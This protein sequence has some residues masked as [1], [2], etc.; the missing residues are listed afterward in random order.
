MALTSSVASPIFVHSIAVDLW[1]CATALSS[2]YPVSLVYPDSSKS[3]VIS[4]ISN[5]VVY[6]IRGG[7]AICELK[8]SLDKI[9][10]WEN[11]FE[12]KP[13]TRNLQRCM[14]HYVNKI[15]TKLR[16]LEISVVFVARPWQTIN[17]SCCHA[18]EALRCWGIT[19]CELWLCYEYRPFEWCCACI[20]FVTLCCG[21]S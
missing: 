2:H 18:A 15:L 4:Q 17:C 9:I 7:T 13:D 6:S 19:S 12:Q 11:L 10:F 8:C 21:V 16:C 5:S 1:R 20:L 14:C 3:T